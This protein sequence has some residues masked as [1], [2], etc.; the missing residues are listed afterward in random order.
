MSMFH[1]IPDPNAKQIKEVEVKKSLIQKQGETEGR[2]QQKT[3]PEDKPLGKQ[4]KSRTNRT[5][6][7]L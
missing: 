2:G 7:K 1:K 5:K 4:G 6:T 3:T